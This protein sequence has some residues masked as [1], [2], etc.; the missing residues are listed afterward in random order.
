MRR[1]EF[2]GVV[3]GAAAGWPL[4][5]HA[6]QPDRMRHIGILMGLAEDDPETKS[7]LARLRKDL[8]KLGWSEG[9]NVRIETR[10]APAGAQAQVLAKEL[11]A[12]QPDVILA[13]SAQATATLQRE[14]RA[15]AIVFVNVS[16]PI[17]AGFVASLARPGG[18]LT[19]LLHYEAGIVGK[20]LAMLK[21][22][23]P[24]IARAALVGDPMNPV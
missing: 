4:A 13:H 8:E 15:I 14:T 6:Q 20:W 10:F 21:E 11:V 19:G 3:G 18:N 22:I 2:L 12:L 5:A 17:G 16:D 1:R 7:R 24:R 23:A 9:R